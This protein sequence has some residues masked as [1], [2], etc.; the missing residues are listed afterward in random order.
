MVRH[1]PDK[2]YPTVDN[3]VPNVD[4]SLLTPPNT[5]LS[6]PAFI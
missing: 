6:L 3:T 4:A 5:Q 2:D 1:C